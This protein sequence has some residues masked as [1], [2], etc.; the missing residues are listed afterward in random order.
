MFKLLLHVF[1]RAENFRMLGSQACYYLAPNETD[2]VSFPAALLPAVPIGCTRVVCISD[3][4]NEHDS[5]DLPT[6]HILVEDPLR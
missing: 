3:T 2:F 1:F 6:G 4:H 5:L